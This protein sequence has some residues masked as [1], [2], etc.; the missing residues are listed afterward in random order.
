MAERLFFLARVVIH[1]RGAISGEARFLSTYS[2]VDIFAGPGGLAEG[3]SSVR[4]H[5]GERAFRIELSIEKEASAYSTLLL[6]TFLR[7]FGDAVPDRYYRFINE[8]GEEPDWGSL[9]PKE[10]AAARREAWQLELGVEDPEDRLD[11]RLD[12]IREASGGNTVLIGGPP[13]QAYSLV[14]R[15][16][17]QGKE[18]YVASKDARHF[19][20]HEYIRILDR[21]RPAAFV[22]ENVKGMLSSSVDNGE[23]RIFDKVLEDLRGTGRDGERY[24]LIALDP[25]SRRPL[26]LEP[27]EPR[28]SDFVIR[29]EDFGVPQARHRVIVVGLRADLSADLSENALADA[30]RRHALTAT[31]G[32]VLSGMPK[33]RSGLSR[34]DDAPEE[35]RKVVAEAMA[36]VAGLDTRLGDEEHLAFTMR[37]ST[38]LAAF[39]RLNDVPAREEYGTGIAED[40]PRN[41]RDWLTD[42][43]LATLPNHASRAHM[44]SDLA[45][46]F[47][48][49]IFAEVTGRSPKASDFPGELA[50]DH[51][52]WKSGKFADRFRV[53]VRDQP[54]T[55]VT[56][57]ISKDG[58][59]FIHPDPMQC[60]SLTVREAARL[61][62]FPDNYLFRG[63]RTQQFVQVGNAVPPFLARQIAASLWAI[64]CGSTVGA[65]EPSRPSAVIDEAA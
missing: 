44:K 28:A 51:R 17:N 1:G 8:G 52:N 62:T 32:Q 57:H 4:G 43:R 24:R 59:Y 33:L 19:L 27:F 15:A 45:R 23:S 30:M 31:A 49:A 16:R 53:Q 2:V 11:A 65:K 34:G 48:A 46:Y 13:C 55:T 36:L 40:C 64:L 10:W 5:D 7:Q 20:Y 38:C 22:M 25:R 3:F 9:H 26:S 50:P 12:A 21:L 60:R 47:F 54:S 41:L 14:G 39:R 56:S 35:W 29:A 61:Q 6:R 58:H 42:H 63:N 18:G 37:A